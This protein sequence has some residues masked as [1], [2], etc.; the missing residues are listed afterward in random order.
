MNR[1]IACLIA[2]A[3]LSLLVC[4][5]DSQVRRGTAAF[6]RGQYAEAL[7]YYQQ[8]EERATDPGLVAF[9]KAVTLYRLGQYQ[10]AELHFVRCR[11]DAA[12]LRRARVLF[13]LGNTLL[14]WSAGRDVRLLDQA[15]TCYSEL[16]SDHCPDSL[17][18]HARHNLE[19]AR[20]LRC[21]AA[22][23]GVQQREGEHDSNNSGRPASRSQEK[24]GRDSDADPTG[25]A[26]EQLPGMA[27]SETTVSTEHSPPPG[28]GNLPVL[29]D[30]EELVDLTRDDAA[31]LLRRETERI[32]QDRRKHREKLL[33]TP[34]R[35]VKD[36]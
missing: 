23:S 22:M 16:L 8:A 27:E 29:P 1:I 15:I 10:E 13:G 3:S 21:E 28:Q 26:A 4:S 19:L 12:G 14:R 32:A 2:V 25:T 9:N 34:S 36:W 7:A 35:I 30:T 18:T 24:T 6:L 11:E 33:I 20:M 31:R 17:E 5:P